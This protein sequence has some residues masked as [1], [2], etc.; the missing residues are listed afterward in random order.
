[1]A[2]E[3]RNCLMKCG[4]HEVAPPLVISPQK[5]SNCPRLETIT[6]EGGADDDDDDDYEY[7]HEDACS[8]SFSPFFVL[9]L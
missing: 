9:L 2:K 4:F 3:M 6:E 7:D 5:Y 1:M 8:F